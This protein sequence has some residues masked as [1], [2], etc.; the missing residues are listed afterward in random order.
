MSDDP[1]YGLSQQLQAIASASEEA[2]RA[3]TMARAAAA[4]ARAKESFAIQKEQH[5]REKRMG[6]RAIEA[7]AEK[8][9]L[10]DVISTRISEVGGD[11]YG[12]AWVKQNLS[13]ITSESTSKADYLGG[14]IK[15]QELQ[16]QINN[17]SKVT[18]AK[19]AF[20]IGNTTRTDDPVL[21]HKL[22]YI[23]SLNP[24]RY[25]NDLAPKKMDNPNKPGEKIAIGDAYAQLYRTDLDIKE[26]ALL[27]RALPA[28]SRAIMRKR[29]SAAHTHSDG[30]PDGDKVHAAMQLVKSPDERKVEFRQN[31]VTPYDTPGTAAAKASFLASVNPN[32]ADDS[33]RNELNVSL[34][35]ASKPSVFISMPDVDVEGKPTGTVTERAMSPLEYSGH[36]ELAI[37]QKKLGKET[38][39]SREILKFLP[40]SVIDEKVKQVA[41]KSEDPSYRASLEAQ[42][43]YRRKQARQITKNEDSD[44]VSSSVG[45]EADF[46]FADVLD[47]DKKPTGEKK[48][49]LVGDTKVIAQRLNLLTSSLGE[50][51]S[52][53]DERRIL[54]DVTDIE[55]KLRANGRKVKFKGTPAGGKSLNMNEQESEQQRVEYNTGDEVARLFRSM[56]YGPEGE[57]EQR[58]KA[59]RAIAAGALPIPKD[60]SG[61]GDAVVKDKAAP[62]GAMEKFQ[63]QVDQLVSNANSIEDKDQRLQY[64]DRIAK[65]GMSAGIKPER[66]AIAEEALKKLGHPVQLTEAG[67]N[68]D[69][70]FTLAG[71]GFVQGAGAMM[72]LKGLGNKIT[73]TLVNRMGVSAGKAKAVALGTEIGG[74]VVADTVTQQLLAQ[75]GVSQN[76][77]TAAGVGQLLGGIAGYKGVD[78]AMSLAKNIKSMRSSWVATS[79]VMKKKMTE[80]MKL[81]S[82]KQDAFLADVLK[83]HGKEVADRVLDLMT[84]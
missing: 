46:G 14:F 7:L 30:T 33:N 15:L 76:E 83:E 77:A 37:L 66:R 75:S 43:E 34:A 65:S 23:N 48:L 1:T 50:S 70:N 20:E 54:K 29:L 4:E 61:S 45:N 21:A 32:D 59:K 25:L 35:S 28:D 78:A 40:Q 22:N 73:S 31:T 47:K 38:P 56:V 60:S 16:D 39:Q 8:D 51:E 27:Y 74:S 6:D 67:I 10:N 13:R 5:A 41:E 57:L 52:D 80:A 53:T 63:A 12:M 58:K 64:I 11:G 36:V 84:K 82:K 69:W 79:P 72:A 49:V 9:A 2:G 81:K 68:E 55:N 24:D 44:L 19:I 3:Q 62:T 42:V 26:R 17:P 71:A 18:S